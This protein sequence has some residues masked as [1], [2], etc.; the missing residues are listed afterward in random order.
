MKT[1]IAKLDAFDKKRKCWNV[2]IETP[3]G[4]NVKYSMNEKT[5]L[6]SLKKALP[7]GMVFPF[8]FGFVPQTLAPDGDPMDVL[9][10]NEEPLVAGCLLQVRP[11][12]VI[13][14]EQ[15]EGKETV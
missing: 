11:V 13:K 12:G 9:V 3:K 10:F 5:G 2:V 15:S 7:E 4:S 8:N 6:L 14:A 1:A